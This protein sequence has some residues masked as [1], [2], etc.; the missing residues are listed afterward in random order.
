TST[1]GIARKPATKAAPRFPASPT[2]SVPSFTLIVTYLL[3]PAFGSV[4]AMTPP[5]KL[6]AHRTGFQ[7]CHGERSEA[8]HRAAKPTPTTTQVWLL[9]SST[10]M[11]PLIL[12]SFAAIASL[13]K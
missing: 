4:A 8:S 9:G 10:E 13:C 1:P 2:H 3:E 11:K 12:L 7:P 6:S 5:D